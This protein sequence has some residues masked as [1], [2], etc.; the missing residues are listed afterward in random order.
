M[1]LLLESIQYIEGIFSK[2]S[3]HTSPISYSAIS[4]WL[5]NKN[6]FLKKMG[7]PRPL[8]HL[9]SSFQTNFT[10][11]TTN[12]CEQMSFQYTVLGFVG[13]EPTTFG[14]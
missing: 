4:F 9:F 2:F 13:F 10:V 7:H 8:F 1:H 5:V 14:T 12:K 3:S 11:C 6:V